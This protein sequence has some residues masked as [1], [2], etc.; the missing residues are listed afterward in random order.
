MQNIPQ[1]HRDLAQIIWDYHHINHIICKS[2][3]ILVLWSHDIRVVDR[4]V[5]L[6]KQWY[7][8][9]MLFSWWIGRLTDTLDLFRWSTEA[10]VFRKRAIE[11]WIPAK[12][13]L[14]ETKSTNT[15]ENIKFS[16]EILKK[17]DI[18]SI[19]I[20]QKP[21]MERRVLA[22]FLAQYPNK[23]TK[24]FVTSPNI[25]LLEYPN[26]E[27]G[28]DEVINIMIWDLQRIIEYP[29][30]GYQVEQNIPKNV[31][32]AYEKLIKYWYTSHII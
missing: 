12:D 20:V 22:T 28:L 8:K 26:S 27:I 14:T 7:S 4:A 29:K 5:E 9:R 30:K 2:D 19:I 25:S 3:I 17:F 32:E 31:L 16:Y 18:Q 11:L 13:I 21:Y 24:F 1:L 6:Y 23:N 10:E 15:W